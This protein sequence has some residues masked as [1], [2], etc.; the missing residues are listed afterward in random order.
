MSQKKKKYQDYF[1]FWA[2]RLSNTRYLSLRNARGIELCRTQFPKP[3]FTV[4]DPG[5][6]LVAGPIPPAKIMVSGKATQAVLLDEDDTIL[7]KEHIGSS[8]TLSS[9]Y[10]Q[11]GA[12]Q[13]FGYLA[14]SVPASAES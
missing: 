1:D 2:E 11:R 7:H 14:V 10:L 3:P 9:E 8:L 5:V 4:E 12:T 13:H 6:K